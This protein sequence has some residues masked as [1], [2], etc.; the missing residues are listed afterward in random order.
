[1]QTPGADLKQSQGK[2]SEPSADLE[3]LLTFPKQAQVLESAA[4]SSAEDGTSV[5][6]A[7]LLVGS[8]TGGAVVD[9]HHGNIDEV[10]PAARDVTLTLVGPA[11]EA[12]AEEYRPSGK[13]DP[14]DWQLQCWLGP[15]TNSKAVTEDGDA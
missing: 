9:G 1:M 5:S 14:E 2:E 4:A 12:V 7:S 13:N 8:S 6:V 11:Q 15:V 3:Y 10:D